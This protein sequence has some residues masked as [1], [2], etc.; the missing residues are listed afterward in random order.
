[1]SG[2]KNGKKKKKSARR[3]PRTTL[4]TYRGKKPVKCTGCV[5]IIP[6]GEKCAS[7]KRTLPADE[8]KKR[9]SNTITDYFCTQSCKRKHFRSKIGE[10]EM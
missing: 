2:K 6:P 3:T 9:K 8:K 10:C 4:K 5:K 7:S 1:M